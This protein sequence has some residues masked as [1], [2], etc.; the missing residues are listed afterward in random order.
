MIA[1]GVF[2]VSGLIHILGILISEPFRILMVIIMQPPGFVFLL[3]V[4]TGFLIIGG[5][6]CFRRE[7]WRA[8]LASALFAAF[9]VGFNIVHFSDLSP[10]SWGAP[11]RHY[12]Y[13]GWPLWVMLI[14]AA[15]SVIFV[16]CTKKEWQEISDLVD[17]NVSYG[18][19]DPFLPRR[20]GDVHN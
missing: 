9:F 3:G 10:F 16:V 13:I 7:Y 8:C 6:L 14:A 17:G 18:R 19:W 12:I 20:G 5:I 2:F 11:W 4:A 15:I 1:L